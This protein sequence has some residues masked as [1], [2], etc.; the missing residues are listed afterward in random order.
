M[1]IP[2]QRSFTKLMSAPRGVV[3]AAQWFALASIVLLH[4]T[5]HA[6]PLPYDETA[7]ANE[8]LQS[9]IVEAQRR[10]QHVLVIFGANWC[11]DC[12]ALDKSFQGQ[13]GKLLRTKFVVVKVDVGNFDKNIDLSERYGSPTKRGIPAA[14]VLNTDGK[15]LYST[16]AGELANARKMSDTGL[17]DFFSKV[18]ASNP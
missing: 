5:A 9:G 1:L 2:L 12:R 16:K 17:Y 10:R 8:Q 4:L 11:P 15:V 3:L 6:A 13:V 14:V 7:N 18:I